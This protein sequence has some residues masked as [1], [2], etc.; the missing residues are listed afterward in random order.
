MQLLCIFRIE[1]VN[2]FISG[3]CKQSLTT[4][5]QGSTHIYILGRIADYIDSWSHIGD[6]ECFYA[7][8]SSTASQKISTIIERNLINLTLMILDNLFERIS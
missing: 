8:I 3:T 4:I 6:I 2:I 1:N 7:S 5:T